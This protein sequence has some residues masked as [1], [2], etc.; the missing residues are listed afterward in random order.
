M[1][2]ISNLVQTL[3][4]DPKPVF[5]SA[6]F[7]PDDFANTEYRVSF[8][9]CG[10]LLGACASSTGRENFGLLLGQMASLS[11]LGIPGFLAMTAATVGEALVA[12]VNNLDLHDDGGSCSLLNENDYCRLSYMVHLPDV[13]GLDQIYD[14]TTAIMYRTMRLLCGNDWNATQVLALRSRPVETTPWSSYYRAAV[15]YDSE[16]CGIVFPKHNLELSPPSAD[17][18]LHH[19]LELEAEMFHKV[20]TNDIHQVLP[21]ILQRGLLISRYSAS[22]IA[23]ALRLQERTLQRHLKATGT[24]FRIELD[25]ARESLSKQLLENSSRPINEIATSIG[26]S[27]SSSFVR[28]FHRWTGVTPAAWRETNGAERRFQN[29]DCS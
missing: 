4:F 22:D 26:Y 7:R 16:V 12:L 17:R 6:G 24:S 28:A 14:F 8:A 29:P 11:H 21:A 25:A 5:E 13:A 20:H 27:G 1:V 3:G 23:K 2:N 10:D 15:L 19:H 18:L 9:K